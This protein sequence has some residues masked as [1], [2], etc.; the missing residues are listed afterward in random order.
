MS[1]RRKV[2]LTVAPTGGMAKKAQ[3]PALPTTPEEIADTVVRCCELGASV[4]AIHARR[5]DEQA[6]CNTETYR[7][8]NSLIRERCEIVLN[9]STGGGIDGDLLKPGND[10]MWEA[11]FDERIKGIYGGCEMA[12]LD[13][14]TIVASFQ[15]R[16]MVV[17]TSP[18]RCETL[19]RLMKEAGVKPEWEVFNPAHLLQDCMRLIDA[20]FDSAPYYINIVLGVHRNFQGALPYSPRILQQMVDLLPPNSLWCVSAIAQAQLPA[21]ANAIILGGHA[22]VGLEDTLYYEPGKLATNEQLVERAVRIIRELGCEP[23]TPAEAREMMGL[24]P[25]SAAA[26]P[27]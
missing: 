12:T 3:N 1:E 13:C 18:S 10:G 27:A 9:N 14:E 6:T 17:N 16:E 26:L 5:P 4:V 11:D 15:G 7:R 19:A 23:A 21:L 8:I 20:G 2:I 25:I 24:A 22:R